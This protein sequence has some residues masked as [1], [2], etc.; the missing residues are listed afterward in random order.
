MNAIESL[1]LTLTSQHEREL[2][3]TVP[4]SVVAREYSNALNSVA[5]VATRPG[6][7]PGKMPKNMVVNF[8]G[9]QIKQEVVEKL[10]EKSFD[11]ACR[12]KE[13]IPVSKPKVESLGEVSQDKPFSYRAAFQI[14]P[15]VVVEHYQGLNLQIKNFVFNE[16][17]IDDEITALRESMATFVEPKNRTHITV[18]DLVQCDSSVKIDGKIEPKYSHQD[19]AVP[20]FAENVPT[21][22]KDA[23]IGKQIGEVAMVKYTLPTDHQESEISGKDCEMML[24]I[25]SFKERVLPELNDDFAK[26]VSDKFSTVNDIKEAIRLRLTITAKR[27]N[28]Y[29]KQ[30]AITKALVQENPMDVPPVLV[31]KMAFSLINRELET[32][33]TKAAEQLVKNRWQE[34]WQAV[35][36]RSL[37]RVKAELIFEE[38]I[39]MLDIKADE[40]EIAKHMAEVKNSS[41]EDAQYS[42]QVGKLLAAIEKSASISTI[43]EPLFK[44][45]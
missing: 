17:D 4:S 8:Y 18:N 32:M 12:E 34:M 19:Y 24:T 37:F 2:K 23:L 25:K 13:L 43:D 36:E 33:D 44:N 22:L 21:D 29:F 10:I 1:E 15:K 3:V 35:Q 39:K 30:E 28:E 11:D 42:I 27:R 16:S 6:F 41:R 26:D 31:E 38:L 9:A 7:R 40:K 14:K 20:L 45:G 5:R